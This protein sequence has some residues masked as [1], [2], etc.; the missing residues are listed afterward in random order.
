MATS[1]KTVTSLL[2]KD[3]VRPRELSQ[4]VSK[5]SWKISFERHTRTGAESIREFFNEY[6]LEADKALV[7]AIIERVHDL[8]VADRLFDSEQAQAYRALFPTLK[9]LLPTTPTDGYPTYLTVNARGW[10]GGETV[11]VNG[12]RFELTGDSCT[13]CGINPTAY[14]IGGG[15][16]CVSTVECGWWYCA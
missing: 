6:S 15:V 3:E 10:I 12:E 1:T 13:R 9:E 16:R 8:V 11:R 2:P 5:L 7:S 4:V 14:G